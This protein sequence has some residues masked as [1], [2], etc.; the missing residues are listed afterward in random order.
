[1]GRRDNVHRRRPG[2]RGL[3]RNLQLEL[4]PEKWVPV[5]R[6][7]HA[8]TKKIERDD[9]SKKSHPALGFAPFGIG[10]REMCCCKTSSAAKSS[11]RCFFSDD[12]LCCVA[13]RAF[14]LQ[15]QLGTKKGTQRRCAGSK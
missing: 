10:G 15:A 9:D 4:D 14:L 11:P 6:K 2:R 7:D 3:V 1:V 12:A 5:F 8:L 13:T